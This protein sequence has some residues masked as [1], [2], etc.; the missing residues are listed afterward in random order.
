MRSNYARDGRTAYVSFPG[1]S[2]LTV[3]PC[4]HQHETI[5]GAR[6]CGGNAYKVLRPI[7][8]H[9][10]SKKDRNVTYKKVSA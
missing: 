7:D 9:S 3:G 2:P 1:G 10:P 8:H 6:N 4:G 5:R